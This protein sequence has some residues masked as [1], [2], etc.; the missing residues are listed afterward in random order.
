MTAY[1]DET[2][3]VTAAADS[4]L[5]ASKLAPDGVSPASRV[6]LQNGP[7]ANSEVLYRFIES[8]VP[9]SNA[10]HRLEVSGS[11]TIDGQENLTNLKIRLKGAGTPATVFVTY[12]R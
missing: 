10:G 6:V 11:V 8:P 9:A 12:Y 1:D 3:S 2:L 5:D 7:L 4:T